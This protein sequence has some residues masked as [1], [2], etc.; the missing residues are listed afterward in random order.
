MRTNRSG[1]YV[2]QTRPLVEV[3]G[4]YSVVAYVVT[5]V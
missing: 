2:I 5:P 3:A 4:I 1:S